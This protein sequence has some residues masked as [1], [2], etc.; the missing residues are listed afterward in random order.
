MLFMSK[1]FKMLS[2]LN[3]NQ[4]EKYRNAVVN[5]FPEIVRKSP[6]IAAYWERVE[7]YFP[8]Y[9]LFLVSDDGDIVAFINSIAFS[10]EGELDELPREGW[11]WMLI[12]GISDYEQG[13]QANSLGG[14][15][16]IVRQDY[17]GQGNSKVIIDKAKEVVKER[18]FENFVI[19]IRPTYKHRHPQMKMSEYMHY[20]VNDKIYDPWI[21]THL[22]GGAE[23]LNI[24]DR[25]M[26][27]YGSINFWEGIMKQPITQSG[28]Y[29]IDGA[30]CPVQIDVEKDYGEYFE[31]NI[32]ISY[33]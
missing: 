26:H 11:D 32:W 33:R 23:I 3:A 13:I 14:L 10:W 25:A 28:K 2:A 16:I 8:E 6:V 22:K 17:L 29:V 5:A 4:I 9:Q 30:L 15:Q 7:R 18:G 12:K 21:R 20:R 19:P 24:C 31:D 27:V 1:Q